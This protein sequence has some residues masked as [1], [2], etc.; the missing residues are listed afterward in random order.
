[1]KSETT[2]VIGNTRRR[3][4][5]GPGINN[6][7]FSVHKNTPI[8]ERTNL[9]FRAEFFNVFNHA[10]FKSVEGDILGS[11]GQVTGARAP[12]LG[13]VA[14]VHARVREVVGVAST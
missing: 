12:R 13:Q 6:W 1:M 14:L 9:E 4:F 5:H 7:D 8:T 10:Q 2:G 11:M 3:F